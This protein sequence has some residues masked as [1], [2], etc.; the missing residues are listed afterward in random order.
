MTAKKDSFAFFFGLLEDCAAD[1]IIPH[2]DVKR[3]FRNAE[4]KGGKEGR[5]AARRRALKIMNAWFL[6][7]VF[8]HFSSFFWCHNSGFFGDQFLSLFLIDGAR[9][10][11][12]DESNERQTN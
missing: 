8:P 9:P 11:Q 5:R 2:C 4:K 1:S 7:E 10:A 6:S 12:K 3:Q